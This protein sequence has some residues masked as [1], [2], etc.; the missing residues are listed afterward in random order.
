MHD[1]TIPGSRANI[2][3]LVIS[4]DKILIVDS[5]VWKPG[6]YWTLAGKTRRGVERFTPAEKKTVEMARERLDALLSKSGVPHQLVTPI[7]VVWPSRR[8]GAVRS[9]MLRVP[10]ARVIAGDRLEAYVGK[11]ITKN[12]ANGIIVRHLTP[13]VP[14]AAR[15]AGLTDSW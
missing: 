11:F 10:G 6:R 9:S 8:D 7:L 15:N 13:L 1:L 2:D 4:G 5:K 3:H 14:K 12:A